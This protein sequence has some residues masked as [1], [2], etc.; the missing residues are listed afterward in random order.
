MVV[1]VSFSGNLAKLYD[2]FTDIN[3]KA[4]EPVV[5]QTGSSFAVGKVVRLLERSE[6]ATAWV[7]QKVD[8]EGHKKRMAKREI[9]ALFD[10]V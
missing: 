8:V 1:Q 6:K 4:G 9:D 7:V 2:Y 10:E 5:V 3:L